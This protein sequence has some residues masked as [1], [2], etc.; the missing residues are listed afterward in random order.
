MILNNVVI[1]YYKRQNWETF[2]TQQSH[3]EFASIHK[4]K[5]ITRYY[6]VYT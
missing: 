3:Q 6:L 4:K 1:L 5:T 2:N